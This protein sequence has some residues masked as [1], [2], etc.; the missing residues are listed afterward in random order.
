ME[1]MSN[2]AHDAFVKNIITLAQANSTVAEKA[3]AQ[4]S[5]L[6]AKSDAEDEMFKLSRKSLLTDKIK[7][8]DKER[9]KLYRAYRKIVK[10][11]LN[12]PVDSMAE[13]ATVLNQSMKD[14]GINPL[15]Q[16]DK[17]TGLLANLLADHEGTLSAYVSTLGLTAHVQKLR[18]ANNEL[19]SLILER[20]A[21]RSTKVA[22]AMKA[23][24]AETNKAYRN[25]VTRVNALCVVE[26]DEGYKDFVDL[27]NAEIKR[28]REQVIATKHQS[29]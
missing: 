11:N 14:Y 17:E 3:A 20:A 25:L 16:L 23:A 2:G 1:R 7:A 28:F 21:E 29:V 5:A 12:S 13:A 18:E 19:N 22:G 15:M 8:A 6:K 9:D 24:R 26:Y 10:G 4:I 27:V